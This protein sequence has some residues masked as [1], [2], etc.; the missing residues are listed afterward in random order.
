MMRN[1]CVYAKKNAVDVIIAGG[2]LPLPP[3]SVH[4]NQIRSWWVVV[5]CNM[6]A[7]S[8]LYANSWFVF[9]SDRFKHHQY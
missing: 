7:R 1:C 2:G 5:S 6:R 3:P 9:I 4:V 8:T